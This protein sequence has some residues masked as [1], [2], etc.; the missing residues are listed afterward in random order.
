[1][2]ITRLVAGTL[3]AALIGVTPIALTAPAQA[4]ENLT[5]TTTAVP[6]ADLLVYGDEIYINSDVTDSKGAPTYD[7][8]S[9]LFAMESGSSTWVAVAT[10]EAS[11]GFYDVKPKRNTTYK[12]VY[13][14]YAATSSF[15]NNLAPSESAPFEVAVQRKVT[16]KI[17][18]L[19][20]FGKVKPDYKR[21]KVIIKRKAGKRF[22]KFKTLRTNKKGVF[23][24]RAPGRTG[25]KF[26]VT[27]PADKHYVGWK[28]EYQVI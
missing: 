10:A 20:V 24:F 3:T 19:T 8:T 12:I 17:K 5:T 23:S 25:F 21:K 27:I 15:E 18:G 11:Y 14:G 9:T 7:G 22:V 2:R 1:M 13:S 6:N 26:S 28:G 4:T 16:P